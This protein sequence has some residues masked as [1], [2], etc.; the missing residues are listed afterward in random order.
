MQI[1]L[2]GPAAGDAPLLREAA[3]FL[4]SDAGVDQVIYLG[5]DA[6]T[7]V[8]MLETWSNEIWGAEKD[9]NAFLERAVRMAL[10]G[11]ADDIDGLLED[12]ARARRLDVVRL[13]PDPPTR[14]VEM[15]ADRICVLVHDKSVL[16]E[17]DIVNA[18]VIVYGRAQAAELNR[19]GNRYFLTPGPLAKRQVAVLELTESSQL[20]ASLFELSG[21]PIWQETLARRGNKVHVA[22]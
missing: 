19:F 22:P 7:L 2:I 16:D 13:L 9:G 1:G 6:A 5:D 10:D 12:E 11:S 15:L 20:V 8:H 4:V 21:A 18:Q 17:E 3:E 14:A